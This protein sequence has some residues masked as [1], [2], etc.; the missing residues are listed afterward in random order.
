MNVI[1][2]CGHTDG[3]DCGSGQRNTYDF[4][5]LDKATAETHKSK[6]KGSWSTEGW[7]REMPCEEIATLRAEL[8]EAISQRHFF[9]DENKRHMDERDIAWKALRLVLAWWD[10]PEGPEMLFSEG[11]QMLRAVRDALPKETQP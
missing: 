9:C 5:T 7:Y 3:I 2:L 8:A 1:Y 11:C 4:V 6:W 10:G